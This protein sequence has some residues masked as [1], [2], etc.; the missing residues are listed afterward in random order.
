MLLFKACL[1]FYIFFI[2]TVFSVGD[3]DVSST[4][5]ERVRQELWTQTAVCQAECVSFLLTSGRTE[6]GC[7]QSSSCSSCW[8]TCDHLVSRQGDYRSICEPEDHH[9]CPQGCQA[10]C[11][12]MEEHASRPVV[13]PDYSKWT[14]NQM[15]H[16]ETLSTKLRLL[17]WA[18]PVK[19]VRHKVHLDIDEVII[20]VI[21]QKSM[22]GAEWRLFYTTTDVLATMD[23]NQE[24]DLL[25][26]RIMAVSRRGLLANMD[27]TYNS[28]K[29]LLEVNA[30]ESVN[31][32]STEK[33][34][35]YNERG[36]NASEVIEIMNE[37]ER[38]P[39]SSQQRWLSPSHYDIALIVCLVVPS[40]LLVLVVVLYLQKRT[41]CCDLS[42]TSC[43]CRRNDKVIQDKNAFVSQELSPGKHKKMKKILEVF[44]NEMETW[45]LSQL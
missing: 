37:L 10:A 4:H 40:S 27:Y 1:F 16:T 19:I 39:I 22:I 24:D 43:S 21:L 23:V 15:A 17:S 7:V 18:R 6:A 32:T 31:A 29:E 2:N 45:S 28:Q 26:Y 13:S 35:I 14:F 8:V 20:Y 44:S 3:E 9:L 34:L 33:P 30:A 42:C 5:R 41:M 11:D 25:Y 12:I 38:K 36:E